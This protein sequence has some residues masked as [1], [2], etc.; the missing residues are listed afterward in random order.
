MGLLSQQIIRGAAHDSSARTPPPR[1]HPDTRVKLIARITAWFDGQGRQELILWITGPAGVGKSAV[2][3]TFAEHLVKLKLLGASV[4]FSRPNKRNNPHGVFITIAY[5]LATRI[6][7]YRKFIVERLSLDPEL[8]NGDVKAQF[9][10]FI[11]E[12]FVEKKIGA[13]GERWGILLDGLDELE[14]Q[15]RQCEI[16]HLISTF[17]HEHRDTPL[18]WIIASR[19]EPHISNTFDSDEV[20]RTSWLEHIPINSTEACDDVECF[21]RSSFKTIQKKFPHSVRSDWPSETEF[22]KLTA[23]ASGLFIYA[24]VVMQFIGD[25]DHADPV[26]QLEV[27]SSI[28][29]HS[30]AAP[31]KENPFVHLDALYRQILSSIPSHL[32]PNAKRLLAYVSSRGDISD[33]CR[34]TGLGT[35][36]GMSILFGFTPHVI[37]SCV[38][39]CHSTLRVPDWKVAHKENMAFLHASFSDYLR[40]SDRSEEFYIGTDEDADVDTGLRLL[41]IWN[42]CSGD[43]VSP[44]AGMYVVLVFMENID[45][46]SAAMSVESAWHRYCLKWDDKPWSRAITTFHKYLFRDVVLCLTRTIYSM[47]KYPSTSPIYAQLDKVHMIKLSYYANVS[48]VMIVVDALR[49]KCSL[50]LINI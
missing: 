26:L 49:V 31:T 14:G 7:A 8:L 47:S 45:V 27:L 3:Q 2:V 21:L 15:S 6:E 38:I 25:P 35:L 29:D 17:V 1:C 10:A 16:I 18:I 12:P 46:I 43:D 48:G 50:L 9:V 32:W 19:P 4:F 37:Y 28:I 42:E 22:L 41:A 23:A 39:K 20:R 33:W 5:Q 13:G 44:L 34:A 11:V 36:R 24:E 40:D 30:N